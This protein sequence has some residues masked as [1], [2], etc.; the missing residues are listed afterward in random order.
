MAD[1]RYASKTMHQNQKN[2]QSSGAMRS[3][4]WSSLAFLAGYLS[5]SYYSV[6]RLGT[7]INHWVEVYTAKEPAV[8]Q[9]AYANASVPKPK[10]EFYTLLTHEPLAEASVVA[11][12]PNKS[13]VKVNAVVVA[14]QSE[15]PA[16][17]QAAMLP[18]P[19]GGSLSTQNTNTVNNIITKNIKNTNNTNNIKE[20]YMIQVASFRNRYDAEK[21]RGSLVLKGFDARVVLISQAGMAWYRVIIGPFASRSLAEAAQSSVARTERLRGMIRRV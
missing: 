7:W 1:I 20:S 4:F 9:S 3:L 8:P 6:E 5:A 21:I 17:A 18:K 15:A 10:F 11:S 19:F 16:L 14:K 2:K 13:D 12:V